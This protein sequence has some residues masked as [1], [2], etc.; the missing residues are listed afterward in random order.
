MRAACLWNRYVP[1]E[2]VVEVLARLPDGDLGTGGGGGTIHSSGQLRS[3]DTV[4]EEARR[5]DYS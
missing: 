3:I 4:M 2:L 1:N 5:F